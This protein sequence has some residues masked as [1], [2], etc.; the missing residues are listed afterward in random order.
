[1]ASGLATSVGSCVEEAASW[2]GPVLVS[3]KL[4]HLREAAGDAGAMPELQNDHLRVVV[5]PWVPTHRF[6]PIQRIH[7]GAAGK[8]CHGRPMP[9]QWEMQLGLE[10]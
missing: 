1:M 3:P 6:Q 8:L 5:V 10:P 4:Y 7:S 2:L 9:T